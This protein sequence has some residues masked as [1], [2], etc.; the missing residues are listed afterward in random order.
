MEKQI[1]DITIIIIAID[2]IDPLEAEAL[3]EA[4]G[5]GSAS[6]RIAEDTEAVAAAAAAAATAE[7]GAATF[8]VQIVTVPS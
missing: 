2:D 1:D 4:S 8:D 7:A 3:E 5:G 6:D